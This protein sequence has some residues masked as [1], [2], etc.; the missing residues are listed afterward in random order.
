VAGTSQSL[1][2]FCKSYRGDLER[3]ARLVESIRKHNRDGLPCYLSVPARDREAFVQALGTEGIEFLADEDVMG[4]SVAQTWTSQQLV[5]LRFARLELART[6]VWFDSDFAVIRDFDRH[7]FLAYDDVPY[8]LFADFRR[9]LFQDSILGDPAD[10]S[11]YARMLAGLER[12]FSIIRD[13]FERRGPLY[14][15]GPPVIWSTAVVA[16]LERWAV[17][18][19][20]GFEMLLSIAPFELNWY[21]EFLFAKQT[22]P[23]VP[24][25][26][27]A[28]HFTRDWELQ[29]FHERG[30]RIS[31]LAARG[32]LAVNFASK[33]MADAGVPSVP[34]AEAPAPRS[35]GDAR[36]HGAIALGEPWRGTYH[37]A[38]WGWALDALRPLHRPDGIAV[39]GFVEKKFGWGRDPGDR[40][41]AFA[42]HREPWV[43]FWHNP[44][45]V[46]EWFNQDRQSPHD[47]LASAEWRASAPACQGLFTL[48]DALARWLRPRVDVPV[49]VLRHPSP[50]PRRGF[51]LDAYRANPDR[52]VAQVGWWLRRFVSL[53][54]LPTTTLRKVFLDLRPMLPWLRSLAQR[55]LE[56]VSQERFHGEVTPVSYLDNDS[57]DEFLSRNIV[58]LHLYDASATNTVVECIQRATPLLVNPLDAIVEYLGPAYPFYFT[59]LDEAAAKAEDDAAIARAHEYLRDLP[60]K[61][62]LTQS[63]FLRGFLASEI[64]VRLGIGPSDDPPNE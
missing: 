51:S 9:S 27:P 37:R 6:I 47:I 31:D 19:G 38:G 57:Y 35:N 56:L 13:T 20:L 12:P 14:F 46:P 21:G 24:R 55:E 23:V 50:E 62:E 8:T 10:D 48:S 34:R 54:L 45:G 52:C 28:F 4:G 26:D 1:A 41:N 36:R 44:P 64:C 40:G 15:F 63:A 5:K 29:R 11:Q 30:F 58:M 33:W 22:I 43:G 17:E 42:S 3:C 53:R 2:L 16:A 61:R 60:I 39:E 59:S 49:C 7:E 18:R 25:I 32:F